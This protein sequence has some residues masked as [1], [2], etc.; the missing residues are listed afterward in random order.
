MQ[1]VQ[2]IVW[3]FLVA[4]CNRV[5]EGEPRPPAEPAEPA[6]AQ[7]PIARTGEPAPAEK[8][9]D[10]PV[11][12]T[13]AQAIWEAARRRGVTFRALGQEPGWYLELEPSRLLLVADYGERRIAGAIVGTD[14][15][16]DRRVITYRARNDSTDVVVRVVRESNR[17]ACRDA[18]SGFVIGHTVTIRVDSL[19]Y[20]G[21]GRWLR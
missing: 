18:M 13:N 17:T 10:E 9:P 14:T 15:S 3:L 12:D 5:G 21:C 7:P 4:S 2:L 11:P 19:T 20:D 6:A 8:A 1:R 16:A